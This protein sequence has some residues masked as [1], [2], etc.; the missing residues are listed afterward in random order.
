MSPDLFKYIEPGIT[1]KKINNGYS[2]YTDC[3]GWFEIAS[4]DELTAERFE[5]QLKQLLDNH[6]SAIIDN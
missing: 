2:V 1:I 4:L 6:K 5:D 3:T